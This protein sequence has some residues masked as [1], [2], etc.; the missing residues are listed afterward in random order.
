[1]LIQ[2]YFYCNFLDVLMCLAHAVRL[3]PK[4]LLVQRG[5]QTHRLCVD[6]VREC[7]FGP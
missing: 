4:Q 6:R 1:M 7:R 3:G 5:V 2:L